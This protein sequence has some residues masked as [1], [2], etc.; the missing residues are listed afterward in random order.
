MEI[1]PDLPFSQAFDYASQIT[2][3]RFTNPLWR[4]GELLSGFKFRAS[5]RE[6]KAFGLSI[7]NAAV[8]RRSKAKLSSA[9]EADS[10]HIILVDSLLDH[11]SDPET[12]ADA[13]VNFLSAGRDTTAQSLTWTVYSL[14]RHPK[15][16]TVLLK[17]IQETLPCS[18]RGTALPLSYEVVS[19]QQALPYAQAIFAEA[20]RLYPAVPFELKESTSATTL[21]DGTSLPAG[22]VVIWIPFGLARSPCIWGADAACFNPDRWLEKQSDGSINIVTRSAF[23]NPVFNAGPRMCI[24]KRMAEVLA[25]RVLVQ[26]MWEWDIEEARGSGEIGQR[27]VMAESLT[28]PMQD[29]LPVK[30]RRARPVKA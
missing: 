30:V 4:V 21:P 24:G 11:I 29:G 20:L 9:V 2:A 13:A 26:L 22:A 15:W 18:S 8:R 27:R 25:I 16:K 3:N 23:E 14:L 7:V 5:L 6:V 10:L 19:G 17:S 12:V 28:A 1:S